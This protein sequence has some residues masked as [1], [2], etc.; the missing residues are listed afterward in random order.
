MSVESSD[1]EPALRE[2]LLGG[3]LPAE[4]E[5][6]EER[7][8]TDADFHAELQATGDDLIHVYLAGEL[9]PPDRER[10]ESHFLSS[11][12]RRERVAFV[13]SLVSAV[14][15]VRHGASRPTGTHAVP[16]APRRPLSVLLPWAAALVVGLGAGGWSVHERRLRQ[17]DAAQAHQREADLR[18]ELTA[19]EERIQQ[20]ERAPVVV[21]PTEGIATWPLSAGAERG[22]ASARPFAVG[23]GTEWVRLRV[24]LEHG[25]TVPPPR[26]ARAPSYRGSLQTAEG[27][28]LHGVPDV[29]AK[30]GPSGVTFDVIVPAGVLR[31]GIYLLA[32][33]G[34]SG[35]D[36]VAATPFVVR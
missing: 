17:Q 20:L 26:D 1:R 35:R 33:Q 28:E 5:E 32:I 13:R 4:R 29:P 27:K 11:S 8:L 6:I 34:A 25:L 16:S 18:R 12:R 21:P 2:Y 10:F 24:P 30:T 9:P 19:Q 36:E 14:D 3:L 23:A 15:R 7:L 31:P 22:T